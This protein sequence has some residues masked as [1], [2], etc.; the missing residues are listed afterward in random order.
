[1]LTT[2]AQE[3]YPYHIQSLISNDDLYGSDPKFIAEVNSMCSQM[4]DMILI[5]LKLLGDSNQFRS[6]STLAIELFLKIVLNANVAIHKMFLLCVN[7]WNLAM[8][9]RSI[10]DAKLPGK[11]LMKVERY[12]GQT[13]NHELRHALEQLT[14]KMKMKM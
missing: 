10:L 3:N 13:M 12:K 2:A 5:Q 1:M 9:N 8:K 14:T 7:L 6:Q 11:I 4:V